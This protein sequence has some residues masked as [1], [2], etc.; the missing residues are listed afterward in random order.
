MCR[1]CF[2]VNLQQEPRVSSD[3]L[4]A[5]NP[6]SLV[7][8]L[9]LVLWSCAVWAYTAKI[10][11]L[12]SNRSIAHFFQRIEHRGE[13]IVRVKEYCLSLRRSC[14]HAH[15]QRHTRRK[16]RTVSPAVQ[17]I[18][19]NVLLNFLIEEKLIDESM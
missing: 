19:L 18:F 4:K 13:N 5:E 2:L 8:S 11:G 9:T 16:R 14:Q 3:V 10:P 17:T 15:Q 6:V 1:P 12:M 7:S